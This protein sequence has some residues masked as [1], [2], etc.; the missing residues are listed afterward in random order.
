M[1]TD[2]EEFLTVFNEAR[3]NKEAFFTCSQRLNDFSKTIRTKQNYAL[4]KINSKDI[5][6]SLRRLEKQHKIDFANMA[7][8]TYLINGQIIKS[9]DFRQNGK[10]YIINRILREEYFKPTEPIK[11]AWQPKKHKTIWQFIEGLIFQA[12]TQTD[13][14][15]RPSEDQQTEDNSKEDSQADGLFTDDKDIMF[16]EEF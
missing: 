4:G 16:P 14:D 9:P 15:P 11:D 10:P 12:D 13:P 3:N 7:L 8:R 2:S 5:T 1:R 6:P